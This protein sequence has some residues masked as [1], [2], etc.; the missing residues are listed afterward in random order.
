MN[1]YRIHYQGYESNSYL[2]LTHEKEFT[3][4]EFEEI[5]RICIEE[6]MKDGF[7]ISDNLHIAINL[8]TNNHGF[9]FHE[10]QSKQSVSI[11][12][13]T[14]IIKIENIKREDT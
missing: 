14:T 13:D 4:E 9:N 6:T 10:I 11:F 8:M 2:F 1:I 5:F 12:T 7:L 3:F